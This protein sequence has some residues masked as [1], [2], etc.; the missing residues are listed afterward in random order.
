MDIQVAGTAMVIAKMYKTIYD[1]FYNTGEVMDMFTEMQGY[2]DSLLENEAFQ[3]VISVIMVIG[4]GLL[5]ASFLADLLDHVSK[6]DFTIEILF[7]KMLK[8]YMVY[9]LLINSMDIMDMLLDITTDILEKLGEMVVISPGGNINSVMLSYGITDMWFWQWIMYILLGLVPYILAV[10]FNLVLWFTAVSRLFEISVRFVVSPI[11]YGGAFWGNGQNND[12][13]KFLKNTAAAIFQIVVVLIIWFS[14]SIIRV[15]LFGVD[16]SL[17]TKVDG[18]TTII[19]DPYDELVEEN[20]KKSGIEVR[21]YTKDSITDFFDSMV[22]NGE[23]WVGNAFLAS[24]ILLV[25][26]SKK[27]ATTILT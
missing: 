6:G 13:I 1:S 12:M 22:M 10:L 4:V 21:Q 25:A 17:T 24:G 11:V 27:I 20:V 26:K 23:Y 14:L 5:I 18:I 8:N 9:M 16:T 19:D 7:K 3:T 2:L 15:P